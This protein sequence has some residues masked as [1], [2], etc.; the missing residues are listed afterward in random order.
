LSKNNIDYFL[1]A[2][3][4]AEVPKLEQPRSPFDTLVAYDAAEGGFTRHKSGG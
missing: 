1:T 4:H 2:S 3:F